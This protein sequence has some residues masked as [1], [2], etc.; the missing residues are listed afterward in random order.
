MAV[1]TSALNY[2]LTSAHSHTGTPSIDRFQPKYIHSQLGLWPKIRR[3]HQDR[4]A[5]EWSTSPTLP[6]HVI[7]AGKRMYT[8]YAKE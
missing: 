6:V 4:D 8:F 5:Q 3:M 2:L 1:G 7:D